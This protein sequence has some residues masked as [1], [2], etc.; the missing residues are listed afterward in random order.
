MYTICVYAQ[1]CM[2]LCDSVA[3]LLCPCNFPGKSTG[4]GCH[5]LLQGIFLIQGSNSR[6]LHWQADSFFFFF[7]Q[8]DSLSLHH[9]GSPINDKTRLKNLFT[10]SRS[11][12]VNYMELNELTSMV[13]NFMT[14]WKLY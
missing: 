5:F 13:Y 4:M 9:L 14:L 7:W 2:T 11:T 6:L 12:G 3:R 8:A 1:S 10:S